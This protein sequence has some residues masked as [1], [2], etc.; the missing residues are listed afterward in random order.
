VP[1]DVEYR[2]ALAGID[3]GALKALLAADA[4]DNGRSPEQLR[5]SFEKSHAA[6]IAFAGGEIIGTARVLSDGICNAYLVDV[7]TA[8]SHRR[9]GI[10]R[11][12]IRRLLEGLPGQ[13]V[14]L[15]TGHDAVEFYRRLG[16]G[17]QP[18]GM[19]AV[20]G[21]WLEGVTRRG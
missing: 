18:V 17:E 3:W 4:F 5:R 13:H 12:M 20:V 1:S 2:S 11:E 8:S 6:C 7:W 19:S 21:T 16:F 10:A 14:Y 15:Q 9:R